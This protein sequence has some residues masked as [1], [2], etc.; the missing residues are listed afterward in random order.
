MSDS[1]NNTNRIPENEQ[2]PRPELSDVAKEFEEVGRKLRDAM[3][4]A[5]NTKERVRLEQDVRQGLDRLVKEVDEGFGKLRETDAAQKVETRV[6]QVAE[7]VKANQM[8]EDLRNGLITALKGL[9]DALDKMARS[10]GS[11][12]GTGTE[13]AAKK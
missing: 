3:V 5:W 13:T 10:M 6:Q 8:T 7:D 11:A 9:S 1:G 2:Q 4:M 12:E